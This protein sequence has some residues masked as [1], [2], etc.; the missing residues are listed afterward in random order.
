MILE[1]KIMVNKELFAALRALVKEKGIDMDVLCEGIQR[2]LVTAVKRDFNNKDIVFIFK[3]INNL[4]QRRMIQ[5][6]QNIGFSQEIPVKLI[7]FLNLLDSP[8]R[9]QSD[10]SCFIDFRHA[11]FTDLFK[12]FICII[13]YIC[14][15]LSPIDPNRTLPLFVLLQ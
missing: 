10:M 11:S 6:F 3:D 12:K 9:I 15:F 13:N 7:A 2:A 4:D 5:I 1:E 14:H 8:H